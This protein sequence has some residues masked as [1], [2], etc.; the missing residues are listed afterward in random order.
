MSYKQLK[1]DE[2]PTCY[3]SEQTSTVCRGNA[4]IG[5]FIL[6]YSAVAT[7]QENPQSRSAHFHQYRVTTRQDRMAR[8]EGSWEIM[9]AFGADLRELNTVREHLG[10]STFVARVLI[11]SLFSIFDGYAWYLKQK[12]LEGA[13]AAGIQFT[14][15]DLAM[16]R[17]ERTK[18]L[19]SGET[20]VVPWIV[21]TKEN[22]KFALSEY[23]RVRHTHPPLLN[24]ALPAEFHLV[25][26][27]R[28]RITHPKSA[29]D[30]TI[31]KAEAKAVARLLQWF[32]DVVAWAGAQ[33]QNN[34]S[35]AKTRI[36]EM[37]AEAR[38]N[39]PDPR[40]E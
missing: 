12:A 15:D 18:G 38:R 9:E 31:S 21:P 2:S 26:K 10:E 7:T 23:A 5:E 22:L 24:N 30:F 8:K 17:E 4:E 11:R 6:R 14:A 32:M 39:H 34:F 20:R 1:K 35:E 19:P 3:P 27:V 36:A 13:Q 29:G 37:F 16:I 33:E 40:R 28:N 25:A